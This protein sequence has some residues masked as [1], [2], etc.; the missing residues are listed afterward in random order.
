MAGSQAALL[1]AVTR[2]RPRIVLLD[3]DLG[4]LGDGVRLIAPIARTGA[5][6]VVVTASAERGRWGECLRYGARKVLTKS[7]PLNEI[8]A[9]IRRLNQGLP[10]MDPHERDELLQAWHQERQEH[11]ELR[12]RLQRL[13]A[14]EREVLGHLMEG[15]TVRD[16]ARLSVVSE[17][18][19]RTQVKSILAKLEVTSQLAA[20]GLAN[21]TGWHVT[22]P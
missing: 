21:A 6:V 17:A 9:T 18:T 7:R 16:I 5:H 12:L 8:L 20:V 15:H 1:S 10:V 3:L 14:R 4:H 11:H 2:L 22:Q 19:V 13:T